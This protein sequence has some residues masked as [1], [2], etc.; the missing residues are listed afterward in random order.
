MSEPGVPQ[1][2]SSAI[3]IVG[4]C[5]DLCPEIERMERITQKDRWAA[6][7]V[8]ASPEQY[9]SLDA[10]VFRSVERTEDPPRQ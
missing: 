2:L 6:E 10:Y 4:I 9:S 8:Y 7:M 5:Q 1:D 3:A